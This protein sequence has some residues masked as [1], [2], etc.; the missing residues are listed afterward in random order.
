SIQPRSRNRCTKGVTNELQTKGVVAPKKLITGTLSDFCARAACG[1]A[2][3]K[4]VIPSMKARRR[5]AAPKAQGLCGPCYG[6]SQLQQG[7][8]TGGMGSDRH[9]AQQQS[10]GPNVR[11]GSQADILEGLCDVRFTPKSGHQITVRPC[12]LRTR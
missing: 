2:T 12:P 1:H 8:T 6:V 4:A 5:I 10:P 7:F 9:F 3:P 11:Y